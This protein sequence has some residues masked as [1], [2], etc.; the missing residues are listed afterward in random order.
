[1]EIIGQSLIHFSST[2]FTDV[3]KADWVFFYS[4]N[5]VKFFIEQ[6]QDS[7]QFLEQIRAVNWAVMGK[8]TANQLIK[9]GYQPNFIGSGHPST[10]A[11]QFGPLAAAQKVLFIQ[12]KTSKKSVQQ[13]LQGALTVCDLVVYNNEIKADFHIPFCEYL[14]FTSPLNAEAY[15]QKYAINQSQ[16]V[17][18][19][20]N[21]T[22]KALVK[23]GI[24]KIAIADKPTEKQMA[25]KVIELAA[26]NIDKLKIQNT[27]SMSNRYA[28][29]DLGTNTFHLLVAEK[30]E[31]KVFSEIH[32]Q[33][34]YVRLAE[35][36]IA[37]IG[38]APIQRGL[39]ALKTF[40]AI[41]DKLGVKKV[42]ALGTAALRTAT[43]GTT[44]IQKVKKE[45][46]IQVELIDGNR[47]AELI[48][49]GVELAVPFKAANYL[50]M[51]IGGGSVEFII[52]NNQKVH[53]AQSFP[54][55]L[56]V[57]FKKIHQQDPINQQ[58]IETIYAYINSFLSPLYEALIQF[59]VTTLV[60][61]AGTFDVLESILAKNQ[62][63]KHHAYIEVKDFEPLYNRLIKSTIEER[64]KMKDIPDT[65]ADMIVVAFILIEFIL[66]KTQVKEIIVSN[67]ALK[68]GVIAE[69][70]G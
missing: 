58:A 54:I 46:D 7:P 34:F 67:F 3:P 57:L 42:K 16:K 15:Y 17:I 1:M 12:A 23:L 22:A 56:A 62:G 38:A 40:R 64:Y 14:V 2:P 32:R 52:A 41:L 35:E 29:I 63:L 11:L 39:H 60:G 18:A 25:K 68:E 44:F 45:F 61:A 36:G 53:W 21:T 59:P 70:M 24:Q 66:K 4:K 48:Y 13:L 28:V 6:V 50:L 20:G 19:I 69:L 55:G 49:K 51:D 47:E 33:R 10:T 31:N 37:T 9:Y 43:N 65:R 5:G 26:E 30:S 8:G 27:Q